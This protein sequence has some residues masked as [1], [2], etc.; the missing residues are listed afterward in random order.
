MDTP[1]G[2]EAALLRGHPEARRALAQHHH[3]VLTSLLGVGY[4]VPSTSLSALDVLLDHLGC[5]E[6][7]FGLVEVV[8]DAFLLLAGEVVED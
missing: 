2:Q 5:L 1:L 6:D 7:A 8:L 4:P 3:P